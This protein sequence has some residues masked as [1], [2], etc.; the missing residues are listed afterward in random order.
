[1]V[2]TIFISGFQIGSSRSG[3]FGCDRQE[4][5]NR[6]FS[7]V[8]GE[9]FLKMIDMKFIIDQLPKSSSSNQ[10]YL[11]SLFVYLHERDYERRQEV[12]EVLNS[13]ESKS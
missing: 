11:L 9:K 7:S 12:K 8:L 1:M 5:N 3:Q 4:A 13:L 2:S 6:K 10:V